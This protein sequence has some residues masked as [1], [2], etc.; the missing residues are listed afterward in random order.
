MQAVAAHLTDAQII[1]V[2]AFVG[3]KRPWR[4]ADV[5]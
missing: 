1:D 3:S 2:A 5:P 4:H